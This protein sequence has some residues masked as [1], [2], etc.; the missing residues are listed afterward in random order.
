MSLGALPKLRL[1]SNVLEKG[2]SM[3]DYPGRTQ[4]CEMNSSVL[5]VEGR[6]SR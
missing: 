4:I 5:G 6:R 2:A 1:N 3:V